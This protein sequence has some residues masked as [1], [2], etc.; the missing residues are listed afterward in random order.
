M[1]LFKQK[2]RLLRF[3]LKKIQFE[4]IM[5]FIESFSQNIDIKTFTM[6]VFNIFFIFIHDD[7]Q[8]ETEKVVMTEY[9]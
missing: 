4:L 2:L 6:N 5:N 8:T 7:I 1:S 9:Y 3:C